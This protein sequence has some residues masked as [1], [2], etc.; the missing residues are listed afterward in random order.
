MRQDKPLTFLIFILLLLPIPLLSAEYVYTYQNQ[1]IE[2]Q[3]VPDQIFIRFKGG[4]SQKTGGGRI[5]A[6]FGNAF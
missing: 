3:I 5:A 4:R 1:T 2:L 6:P